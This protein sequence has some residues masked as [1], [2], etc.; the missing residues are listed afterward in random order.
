MIEA[1]G[2]LAQENNTLADRMRE[3]S[4]GAMEQIDSATAAAEQTAASSQ[5]VSAGAEEVTARVGE[6]AA[7][8][9]GLSNIATEL[10]EF[11]D[12]I[13]AARSAVAQEEKAA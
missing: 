10:N 1:V 6:I 11:L 7:Q 5:Q 12:W 2:E 4:K 13:G 3:Q 8:A 9:L